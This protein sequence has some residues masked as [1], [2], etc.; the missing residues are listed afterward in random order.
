MNASHAFPEE[1]RVLMDAIKHKIAIER[2]RVLFVT[3]LRK[4]LDEQKMFDMFAAHG[5]LEGFRIMYNSRK[6][7]RPKKQ[8]RNR[9]FAFVTYPDSACAARA[10]ADLNERIIDGVSEDGKPLAVLVAKSEVRVGH[11][12]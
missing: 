4:A 3:N 1:I 7:S 12:Y 2:K 6:M 5:E 11:K 8:W 9:G 10:M